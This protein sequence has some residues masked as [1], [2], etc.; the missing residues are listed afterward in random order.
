MAFKIDIGTR[1]MPRGT[2]PAVYRAIASPILED[3]TH[4]ASDL[5]LEAVRDATPVGIGRTRD[6]WRAKV[7]ALKRSWRARI[8]VPKKHQ[9]VVDVLEDGARPH[10]PP[11]R[12]TGQPPNLVRWIQLGLRGRAYVLT[13]TG[14][15]PARLR[16]KGD[17]NKIGFLISRK[18]SRRGLPRPGRPKRV[19]STAMRKVEPDMAK[20]FERATKRIAF[21]MNRGGKR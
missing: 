6:K 8:G 11:P 18:I 4:E 19:F 17:L 1:K 20:V 2:K 5:V 15:R 7:R 10:R 21:Y 9:V 13:R 12:R 14:R 16:H 3:A